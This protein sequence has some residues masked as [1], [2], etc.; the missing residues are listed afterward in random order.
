MKP[1]NSP[2]LMPAISSGAIASHTSVASATAINS[3]MTGVA[4][5]LVSAS[6]IFCSRLYSL[7]AAK[8]AFS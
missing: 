5:A 8:R 6:F 7:T 4:V 2:A 3:W 1:T